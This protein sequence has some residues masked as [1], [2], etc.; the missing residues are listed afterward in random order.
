MAAAL[1]T[2]FVQKGVIKA[3]DVIVSSP[4]SGANFPSLGQI[5]TTNSAEVIQRSD[6]II[7]AVKPHVATG[8]LQE[9]NPAFEQNASGKLLISVVAGVRI[10]SIQMF[11]NKCSES[12]RPLIARVMPNTPS[13]VGCGASAFCIDPKI[14]EDMKA[15]IRTVVGVCFKSIGII[16]E[17]NENIMDAVTALCGSGPAIVFTFLEAMADAGVKGGVP[18]DVSRRLA[19]QTIKGSMLMLE[20]TGSHPAVLRDEVTSP[21]GTTIAGVAAMEEHGFRNAVISSIDAARLRACDIARGELI[22]RGK[23]LERD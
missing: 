5:N 19:L 2:G 17:V 23:R 14:D 1:A 16:E 21:G 12:K 10:Q 13:L 20:T 15:R 11:L 18:R 4:T 7:L 6:V 3:E 8:V 22:P 9:L